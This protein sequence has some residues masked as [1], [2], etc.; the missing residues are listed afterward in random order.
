MNSR[1][2][3]ICLLSLAGLWGAVC[4]CAQNLLP[5]PGFEAGAGGPSGWRLAEGAGHWSDAAHEGK[6][7]LQVQGNGDDQGYW[8]TE[9]L[10][11]SAGGVYWLQFMGR[12][13][14][15][16]S[17]GTAVAGPSRVN[18]D[19]PM[20]AQWRRHGF[21]F[22]APN[23]ATNDFVRL[24]Q[25]RVKGALS[26]DEA[27]L[28]PVLVTHER[29]AGP[30]Q[31]EIELGEAESIQQGVYRFQPDFNWRGANYHRPLAANR[32]GFNSNRWLFSA[33]A[34]LV[35]RFALPGL[36]QTNGRV[37][38][39]IG[40]YASGSLRVEASRDGKTWTEAA[41]YGDKERGGMKE[42]P[43]GLFPAAAVYLRLSMPG[44]EGNLQVDACDY[45]AGL[46]PA[47]ASDLEGKTWFLQVLASRPELGVGL[48][49]VSTREGNG[50]LRCIFG[51]T[52]QSQ[53][54]L[55]VRAEHEQLS[56]KS[57]PANVQE[58]Q[59]GKAATF[60]PI[61][62][63]ERPGDY[64]LQMKF[65]DAAGQALFV[66]RTQVRLSHLHD[67]RAG[68]ALLGNDRLSVWW[69]ESGWK[70]G[71]S[72]SPP[73]RPA[74]G[75][76]SPAAVSAAQGEFEA[77][78][79]VLT[80]QVDGELLSA[81][82]GPLRN[83]AGRAAPISVQLHEVAYVH[84]TQ[85]TDDTCEADWYPDPLPPL[86]TPRSLP[87][88]QNLPLWLTFHVAR[89]ALPGG[90]TGVLE[91]KSGAGDLRVP[92]KVHVYDFELPRETHL[93][94]ALG[95]GAWNINRYHALTSPADQLAGFEKYLRNFAEHRISPYSFYDYAPIEVQFVGEDTNKQA[96]VDF[97]KFDQAAAK[98]LDE[99]RFNTFQLPL[100]G[101]GGGTFHS[102]YLGELAGFK[103]G[104]P[105]HARLFR[106]YLSQVEDHLRQR[107]WL[108]KA[109]IYWFD[110][111]DP[112][113]Y[114]FVVEGMKRLK[115]AA[116]GLKRMLTE[117]PEPALLG[118][119]DI[120]CGLTPEWTPERVRARREAGEEVWWYICCGPKAPYVGEFID[121]P[122][123]ELRLWPWQSWQYGVSAVLIWATL[124][125]TSPLVYPAPKLQ[126][127][128]ADPMSWVSG[129]GRPV[130]HKSPWGNG[131]GR[132]LYPP[133]RD[134]SKERTPCL[135]E[136]INSLRWEN[137][138]DGMEDY[139]YLWL[140]QQAIQR[141]QSAKGQ[142]ELVKQ[143]TGLLK[144]PADVS[145][146][147]TH[148]T[149]D[150]RPILEH[151]DRVAKMIERLDK[152]R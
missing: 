90:Y 55:K 82:V 149:T 60:S 57:S 97:T 58:I 20:D 127:P 104:T 51:V 113:D 92:L 43:A 100:Q 68:R 6:R 26:F 88:R 143:A 129:Y 89:E 114:E 83:R 46:D 125:W 91:L 79:I 13:E 137:L 69:C 7:A 148:F 34:E 99:Y 101:M 4:G 131:D 112:K 108:D 37:R 36:Q 103:E 119:V 118:H 150:P 61:A 130:G 115:A 105:E 44:P 38:V 9:N 138:R 30:G 70:V 87:A 45:E 56:T 152:E 123:T 122:G 121:H 85:P 19:F 2:H 95:L 50:W 124:Y 10:P 22:A 106:D 29:V 116:P 147:L 144:V 96:R 53:R 81:S 73:P 134:P 98:W 48:Q 21:A 15:G 62:V 28:L 77:L 109:F 24:G 128:W 47:P 135:D 16:A 111:P 27:E 59:P 139:E 86:R 12:R 41:T 23:D 63:V 120:W 76:V 140:L 14:P 11:F 93:R 64:T 66:G 3:W 5:N 18:R 1:R 67:P 136:P 25:W 146:D 84:V 42:L 17:A 65:S 78:Q 151:R 117:Q 145:E 72:R 32:A 107:G 126:D 31:R 74:I 75:P 102:R 142:S 94:S 33:G 35:Y 40:Y 71:R 133:R 80:P 132:F 49:G 39:A 8:R 141:L 110:E 54:A 52:N